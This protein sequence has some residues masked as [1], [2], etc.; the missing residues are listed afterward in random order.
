MGRDQFR[1]T[2]TLKE[3]DVTDQIHT[4]Q[5]PSLFTC[6]RFDE[7]TPETIAACSERMPNS[8]VVIFSAK[9]PHAH[10]EEEERYR[11]VA[12]DFLNSVESRS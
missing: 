5:T 2:G 7:A 1:C 11:Q 4:V 12:D 6:G 10:V 3:F 9:R 8:D